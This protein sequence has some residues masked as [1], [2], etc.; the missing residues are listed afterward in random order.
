M[1]ETV[2]DGKSLILIS[3]A[4]LNIAVYFYLKI[5]K[6]RDDIKSR[7]YLA[8]AAFCASIWMTSS[9]LNHF[10]TSIELVTFFSRLS[11]AIVVG[12]VLGI[13]LFSLNYSKKNKFS[14]IFLIL[15]ITIGLFSL[16]TPYI[17]Q[18]GI[19]RTQLLEEGAVFGKYY[20]VWSI[21]LGVAA[22]ILIYSL[23]DNIRKSSGIRKGKI[24]TI[25]LLILITIFL[26]VFFNL[27]LPNLGITSF[28]FIGQYSTLLFA[29]GSAWIVLQE[30]IY[31]IQY[32][33]A[34]LMALL[35]SGFL[36]FIISWTA[37]KFEQ[38]F[39]KWEIRD[40]LNLK[41]VIF[42]LIIGSL[43]AIF[44]DKLIPKIKRL[45]YYFFNVTIL[46]LDSVEEWL[47]T[48]SNEKID[49]SIYS[50]EFLSQLNEVLGAQNC[51]LF[52]IHS[53]EIFNSNADFAFTKS[54]LN[55]FINIK[56]IYTN[57]D[58]ENNI[59]LIFPMYI[60][61]ETIGLLAF[62]NKKNQGFY[63]IEEIAKLKKIIKI[64]VIA[65]NRYLF[66]K[67]QEQFNQILKNEIA[68]ATEELSSKNVQLEER[69]Q[70]ERDMLDILGHELRTPLSIARNAIDF[71]KK[72][73]SEN[74]LSDEQLDKYLNMSQENIHREVK[75]LETMLSAT[76][77]DN[78]KLIVNFE[79][80]D[81]IDVINDSLDGLRK[82]AETKGLKVI[83]NPPPEAFVLGD[84]DRIQ[85]VSDN[86]IDNAI[87]YTDK[88]TITIDIQKI[89][90]HFFQ[91]S[92]SDTGIG[93]SPKDL[94]K[95]GTK[96]YRANNY[97]SSSDPA[98]LT[99][100]RPGGTGIGLYVTFALIKAMGGT[101]NVTSEL[102]KGTTFQATF[103]VFDPEAVKSKEKILDKF[104]LLK[105]KQSQTAN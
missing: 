3:S 14:I 96:F 66:Y 78:N 31:S 87:K 88:G 58:I 48:K 46:T 77:I 69:F 8:F 72:L 26:T 10:L 59:A 57:N 83:F 53:E 50:Q 86:I 20:F 97:L 47:I 74:K 40:F 43:V 41:V 49:I 22:F 33:F 5:S 63:S 55:E 76:K 27:I 101:I 15:G 21:I 30:K 35:T 1:Q 56:K 2:F 19:P 92:V 7:K 94:K 71:A 99:I 64:L 32:M 16:F 38:Y 17:I 95:I 29:F 102:G 36:L 44:I 28:I 84:R 80:I 25:V 61:N 62:S 60:E 79:K 104:E 52:I 90:S 42:G 100:V 85:E 4:I 103:K 75:L 70:Q 89:D 54:N 23:I 37:Q 9:W 98:N 82:K 6:P 34:N 91:F 13:L 18:I 105:S 67:K 11:Y 51:S 93:I 68:K 24:T 65:I 81:F 73:K 45:F 12:I 39:L